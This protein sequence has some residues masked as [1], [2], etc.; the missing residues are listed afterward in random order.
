MKAAIISVKG[1]DVTL[2]RESDQKEFTI[3]L[4]TLFTNGQRMIRTMQRQ[5]PPSLA[6]VPDGLDTPLDPFGRIRKFVVGIE[7][8]QHLVAFH[9]IESYREVQFSKAH[10][11]QPQRGSIRLM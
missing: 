2:R 1:A 3:K 4:S 9:R 8:F 5:F 6:L 11:A 7:L 10:G